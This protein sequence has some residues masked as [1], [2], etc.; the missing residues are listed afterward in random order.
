MKLTWHIVKK[1]LRRQRWL[2]AVIAAVM[3][4]KI[5]MGVWVLN[6]ELGG[7]EFSEFWAMRGQGTGL[8]VV[9][10][11][12]LLSYL[13]VAALVQEDPLV[14]RRMEWR[15]RPISGA[16][17]LGAKALTI[18]LVLGVV[19]VVMA[20]PWWVSCGFDAS[21]L[22][23]AAW[24]TFA[25]QMMIAMAALPLAVLTDGYARFL[26]WTLVLWFGLGSVGANAGAMAGAKVSAELSG[27]RFLIAL[28]LT[29]LV[30]IG[31]TVHQF[32]TLR[33]KRGI[34]L[35]AGGV[36]VIFLVQNFWPWPLMDAKRLTG[37]A[38]SKDVI[39]E[40]AETRFAPGRGDNRTVTTTFQV[41]GVP[42][43][44]RLSSSRMRQVWT[45]PDGTELE[46]T[47]SDFRELT[48]LSW[49]RQ[50][51]VTIK[52]RDTDWRTDLVIPR[53]TAERLATGRPALRAEAKF[54][55]SRQVVEPAV[56]L[57]AGA[58]QAV[59]SGAIK[60]AGVERKDDVLWVTLVE[61]RPAVRD[62][63]RTQLGMSLNPARTS[64]NFM[65]LGAAGEHARRGTV[66]AWETIG[67]A[68]VELQRVTL[69][70]QLSGPDADAWA[71]DPALWQRAELVK[72]AYVE[73]ETFER[74]ATQAEINIGREVEAK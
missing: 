37:L 38:A 31:V 3:A 65:L 4:A 54:F 33:T 11:E 56:P 13:F 42:E 73:T 20:L 23:K 18:G 53:E 44:Y 28:A 50:P 40:I 1:D 71:G 35:L 19:P 2:I 7:L 24:A 25:M 21:E 16:R 63:K 47:G 27:T 10:L 49:M 26:L 12:V 15:T 59:S 60:I 8:V 34:G 61:W 70:F 72:T 22:A 48:R 51:T 32:L 52:G 46:R 30:A 39:L 17:L 62:G 45:W 74:L 67:V 29:A 6:T 41:H 55:L 9:V 66:Q 64:G 5:G 14:G 69:K 36:V 43:G 68:E 57:R 58:K